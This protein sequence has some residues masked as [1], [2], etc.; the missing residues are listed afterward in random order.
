[1]EHCARSIVSQTGLLLQESPNLLLEELEDNLDVD[2]LQQ[3]SGQFED[4]VPQVSIYQQWN[5]IYVRCLL[6]Y[7]KKCIRWLES[8]PF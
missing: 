7:C 2:F 4:D 8:L 5:L 3:L 6:P 1:M